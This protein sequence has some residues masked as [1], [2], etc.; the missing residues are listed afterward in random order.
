MSRSTT[1]GVPRFDVEHHHY[2]WVALSNTT[3]GMLIVTINS[4]IVLI[5]LP[6]I[7]R[8]IE[9][10]PLAPGNVSYLLWMI[11]GFLLVSAVFVVTTRP[12][13][14]HLRPGEDLQPRLPRVRRIVDPVVARPAARRRRRDVA[15]HRPRHPRHRRLDA[16][17]ELDR[18]PHRRLSRS[19]ARDGPRD[20]HG[21][22][23]RRL[24][25]RAHPRRAAG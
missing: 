13:R 15:D 17:R 23:N 7:F 24:V 11:M 10:D 14:R 9:L 5:S 20:Q 6:A 1:T 22:G 21:L 16:V 3:I 2:K 25:S 19:T 4:S 18:D 12:A 8:G